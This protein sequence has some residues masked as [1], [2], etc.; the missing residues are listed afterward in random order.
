[1]ELLNK[2]SQYVYNRKCESFSIIDIIDVNRSR[3]I[4]FIRDVA[5]NTKKGSK[6]L[7]VGAGEGNWRDFFKHCEYKTQDNGVGE[8][9][10]DYSKTDY[11]GDI[12]KI[13]CEAEKFD[14]I[15]LTEVLEHLPEPLFALKELNRILKKGG[16]LYLTVPFA[17]QEHE[18]PFDYYRYTSYGL[19]HLLDKSGFKMKKLERR[20][21]YFKY[22]AFRNWHIIFMPFLNRKS[23]LKKLSGWVIKIPLMLLFTIISILFYWLDDLLDKEKDLTLGFQI[24]AVKK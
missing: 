1:M 10:W 19:K 6:V 2:I 15:L 23:V 7:D 18:T 8:K 11:K 22:V 24:I 5:K 13:P 20:G 16:S 4:R 21:G 12:T 3:V 14:V 17:F 9:D